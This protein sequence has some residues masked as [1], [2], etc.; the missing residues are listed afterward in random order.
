MP[1]LTAIR[2]I[3][4][5]FMSKIIYGLSTFVIVEN[6]I[7]K[8]MVLLIYKCIKQDPASGHHNPPSPAQI[9]EDLL[10]IYSEISISVKES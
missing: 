5:Y 8:T 1:E 3:L 6:L 2:A 4:S 9:K 10:L 7:I